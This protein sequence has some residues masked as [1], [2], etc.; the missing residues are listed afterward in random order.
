MASIDLTTKLTFS[1]FL[2][3]VGVTCVRTLVKDLKIPITNAVEA[4]AKA[5]EKSISSDDTE[6]VVTK[7]VKVVDKK[8][9]K[10]KG[11]V[12]KTEGKVCEYIFQ[13]SPKKGVRC[14]GCID[15]KSEKFCSKHINKDVEKVK[16]VPEKKVK[17]VE[18]IKTPKHVKSQELTSCLKTIVEKNIPMIRVERNKHGNYQCLDDKI[19]SFL[20]DPVTLE[21]IGLQKEDGSISE[22]SKQDI[23][24][25]KEFGYFFKIPTN[26]SDKKEEKEDTEQSEILK[27]DKEDDMED[28]SFDQ[29]EYD[30]SECDE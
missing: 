15:K 21:M 16:K 5:I 14:V 24:L 18:K 4:V 20:I 13:R 10:K 30:E 3:T 9:R 2:R 12:L 17:T 29:S 27:N 25:C 8:E 23:E 19:S 22:L 7:K 1:E 26:L 11:D 6:S 28:G